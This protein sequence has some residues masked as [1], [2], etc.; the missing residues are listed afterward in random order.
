MAHCGLHPHLDQQ[1]A[2]A[3]RIAR[4]RA[5]LTRIAEAADKAALIPSLDVATALVFDELSRIAADALA[6]PV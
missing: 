1:T 3:C 2:D 4:L 6:V 5:T